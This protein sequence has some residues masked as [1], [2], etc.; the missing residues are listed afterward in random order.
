VYDENGKQV[1]EE[2]IDKEAERKQRE[3]EKKRLEEESTEVEEDF[4]IECD[5]VGMTDS[6]LEAEKAKAREEETK[7]GEELARKVAAINQIPDLMQR[8]VEL[9]KLLAEYTTTET[10]TV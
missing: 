7:Q 3:E 2:K 5:T 9:E 10:Y 1:G 6:D 4:D 8:K